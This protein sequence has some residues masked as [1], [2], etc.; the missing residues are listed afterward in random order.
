M[1]TMSKLFQNFHRYERY[2][3]KN[4]SNALGSMLK[5]KSNDSALSQRVNALDE[6]GTAE[7]MEDIESGT[8]G[9]DLVFEN[10][11]DAL[12]WLK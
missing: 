7:V 6:E 2:D 5:R 1:E 9:E 12:C 8:H 10:H 3:G 4:M 11:Y